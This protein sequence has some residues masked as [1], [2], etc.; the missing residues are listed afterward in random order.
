MSST[1]TTS[2]PSFD[3]HMGRV[4]WFNNKAGYGFITV[5]QNG[6]DTDIFVHHSDVMV[7]NE[8]YK[9][10]VQGEY[11]E[12]LI[13]NYTEG[14]QHQYKAAEVSGINSGKLMCETRNDFRQMKTT[15]LEP[16][17]SRSSS[18]PTPRA[19]SMPSE[20]TQPWKFAQKPSRQGST[21]QRQGSSAGRGGSSRGGRGGR[22][23]GVS[24]ESA[25]E[26]VGQG[27]V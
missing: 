18:A 23:R 4:K 2:T 22:G 27:A 7:V 8:Q 5:K 11:V 20:S 3:R 17:T 1:S 16:S 14:A 10:L 24:R 15:P 9:Y 6:V 25:Q 13:I 26:S 12:F 21:D 19:S